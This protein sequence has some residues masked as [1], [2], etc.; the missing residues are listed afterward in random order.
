MFVFVFPFLFDSKVNQ[1][2]SIKIRVSTLSF[3]QVF[4]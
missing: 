3:G 4:G 2:N 1:P